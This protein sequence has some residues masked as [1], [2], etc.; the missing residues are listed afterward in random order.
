[1]I[2]ETVDEIS[3]MQTHSS[4]TVA[5][6]A[7]EA[8]R[9]MV[10]R[11]FATV[12]EYVRSLERNSNALRRAQRSHASL[13]NTQREIISR[14]RDAD[15]ETVDEAKA[16]TES[17]IEEIVSAVETAKHDAASN[18]V[19]L[20]PDGATILTHDYSSTV[21]EAVELAVQ[22]GRHLEVY[23]TEARPRFLGRK[24]ARTLASLDRV[25]A[26]LVVDSAAGHYLDE[27]DRVAIGMDCIV[28]D[29]LYNRV[30]TFPIAATAAELDVPVSVF[31]SSAKIIEEGFAFE[32]DFR[33]TSEV[34]R[35][36]AEGFRIENPAYDAT[37]TH[38][39]ENVVTNDGI[40]KL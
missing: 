8:L 21:L 2:D 13:Q 4:S 39:L 26:T 38:L 5:I 3:E 1:M 36:P 35:E 6:K 23:V 7:A 12:E 17:V 20:L 14:V 40:Q 24:T 11:E 25:D 16:E 15:P 30:G 27:C 31:G 32:N 18:G 28:D 9:E 10:D 37:P 29:T 19:E 22:E 34:M 33:S